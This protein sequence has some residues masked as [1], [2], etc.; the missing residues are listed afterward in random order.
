MQILVFSGNFLNDMSFMIINDMSINH[1]FS[2]KTAENGA[3]E[4]LE[5][6]QALVQKASKGKYDKESVKQI[7]NHPSTLRRRIPSTAGIATSFL[8]TYL[9][10]LADKCELQL[11]VDHRF[12]G[13]TQ[14][15][16]EK[17]TLGVAAVL[18]NT[19]GAKVSII[20]IIINKLVTRE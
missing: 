8:K 19:N 14:G 2:P 9:P 18:P 5:M 10:T 6:F 12:N 7:L 16:I 1:F 4:L 15:D 20:I 17:K 3:P 13:S 11:A